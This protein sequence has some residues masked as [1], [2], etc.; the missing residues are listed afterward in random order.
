MKS[1]EQFLE[2]ST[3]NAPSVS[4]K[5]EISHTNHLRQIA[6]MIDKK[7]EKIANFVELNSEL[8]KIFLEIKRTLE[9]GLKEESKIKDAV[10][11]AIGLA[12]RGGKLRSSDFSSWSKMTIS[13]NHYSPKSE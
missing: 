9:Y 10:S 2:S 3:E 4:P 5:P 1:F 13:G 6:D 8:L 7:D 12:E 11:K